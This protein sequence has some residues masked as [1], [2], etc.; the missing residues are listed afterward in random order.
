MYQNTSSEKDKGF[1]F[2]DKETSF[3]ILNIYIIKKK[4][5]SWHNDVI[6][7]FNML[8]YEKCLRNIYY[9]PGLVRSYGHE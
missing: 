8:D 2:D 6:I 1:A 9:K 4:F 5:L 3:W 7:S